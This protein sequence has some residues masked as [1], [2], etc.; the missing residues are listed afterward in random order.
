MAKVPLISCTVG[1]GSGLFGFRKFS[2][3]ST[4]TWWMKSLNMV[5][6]PTG[7]GAQRVKKEMSAKYFSDLQTTNSNTVNALSVMT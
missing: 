6:K 7:H 2:W 3:R 1:T 5:A 4:L